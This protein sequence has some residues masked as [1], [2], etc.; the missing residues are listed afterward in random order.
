MQARKGSSEAPPSQLS[1]SLLVLVHAVLLLGRQSIM[2]EAVNR[3]R[4][5]T[6]TPLPEP[7]ALSTRPLQRQGLAVL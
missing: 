6:I 2:C 1:L 7:K 3:W 5:S 4:V